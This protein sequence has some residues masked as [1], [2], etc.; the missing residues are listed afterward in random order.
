MLSELKLA[1]HSGQAEKMAAVAISLTMV[2]DDCVGWCSEHPRSVSN[3]FWALMRGE[4][5]Q[6]QHGSG[7]ARP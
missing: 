1:P 2:V 3:P 6:E 4:A 7:G 5:A